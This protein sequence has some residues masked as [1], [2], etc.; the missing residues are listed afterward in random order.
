MTRK[1]TVA[2]VVLGIVVLASLA[3]AYI[4][5]SSYAEQFRDAIS[6]PPSA[7]FWLGTDELGRDRFARLLYGTRVSLLLA[8][9]AALLSTLIAALIGGAAGYLG[10]RWER[11]LTTGVDLFLSLPWLF[12]LLAVR[13]LLPLNTS[14]VTSVMITFLLLGCLGWAGPARIIRA[15]TRTLVNADYLVQASA[16][17][18]S[19]W[20]LFWRHLLPNLRPILLAQF[21]ISVPLF[22]LS[23]ANL[24]LLG[25]GVSEPLP[26]WGAMLRELE[27][28]S[29]VLKN[30]WMLAPAILLVI[31]VSCLQL[32]LRTEESVS[33]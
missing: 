30:P 5:P 29:A 32:L 27:N 22:I 1:Q 31:V 6:A 24:G 12:L 2:V 28:Y 19:R 10:G 3:A 7:R 17:G 20:R 23:E 18:I 21:W 9:A 25:L 16:S 33:C 8:P 13:A 14:P 4:T 11:L 26:S 15:G